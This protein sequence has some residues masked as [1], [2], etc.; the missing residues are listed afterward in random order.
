MH[1]F[2][3]VPRITSVAM[4]DLGG[5]RYDRLLTAAVAEGKGDVCVKLLLYALF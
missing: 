3:A 4:S 1:L 5:Q 2:M